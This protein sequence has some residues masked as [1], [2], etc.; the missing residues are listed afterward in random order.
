MSNNNGLIILGNTG[1]GKSFI[2]NLILGQDFFQHE[3]SASSVTH[4]TEFQ[5]FREGSKHFSIFNIP[6]LI[7]DN[8]AAV[9]QNKVEIHKAFEM[10]PISIVAFVFNGGAGGRIKEEDIVA[11]EAINKAY[12]FES[13]SLLLI[14]ND[15][16]SNRPPQYEG[17]T[18]VK[19]QNLLNLPDVKVCFLD[20]IDTNNQ[21][22]RQVL[23]RKLLKAV[24]DRISKVHR[25]QREIQLR[26]DQLKEMKAEWKRK[27][28]QLE[29]SITNLQDQVSRAQNRYDDLQRQFNNL[30]ETRREPLTTYSGPNNY[31]VPVPIYYPPPASAW[32]NTPIL[33]MNHPGATAQADRIWSRLQNGN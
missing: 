29:S 5:D 27:Q 18:T 21:Q 15:L 6:G 11:F 25:K 28:S 3:C 22:N 24:L 12:S 7:E 23:R 26:L 30:Q 14:V 33:P 1:S 13:K 20:R 10:R 4:V 16:P 32:G 8:Q 19:L 31:V 17:E 2:G 9:D